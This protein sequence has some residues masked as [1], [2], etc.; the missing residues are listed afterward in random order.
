MKEICGAWTE[1]KHS[2]FLSSMESSFVQRMWSRRRI[3]DYGEVDFELGQ[4]LNRI[5]PDSA[6]ESNRDQIKKRKVKGRETE[7]IIKLD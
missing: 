4:P 7:I 2:A 3:V 1:E 5:L 6:T